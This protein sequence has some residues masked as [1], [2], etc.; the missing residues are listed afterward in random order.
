[1]ARLAGQ[2]KPLN[3]CIAAV[4]L[5]L[6]AGGFLWRSHQMDVLRLATDRPADKTTSV[7]DYA[8][9][10]SDKE[11]DLNRVLKKLRDIYGIETVVVT[12]EDIPDEVTASELARRLI[13]NW[14]IGRARNGRGILILAATN[15]RQLQLSVTAGLDRFFSDEFRRHIQDWPWHEYFNSNQISSGITGAVKQIEKRARLIEKDGSTPADIRRYDHQLGLQSPPR[16]GNSA[17]MK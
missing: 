13:E 15:A 5:L 17:S 12:V 16:S 3:L 10:L 11:L 2:F 6:A 1:M 14:Q 4:L 8:R 7:F 9:L